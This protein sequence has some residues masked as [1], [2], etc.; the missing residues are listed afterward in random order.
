M[1]FDMERCLTAP[2]HP[3][4]VVLDTDAYNEVDD[5][6]AIAY[7][8]RSADRLH[9]KAIYAA[10]FFNVRAESAADG[11]EKSHAEILNVLQLMGENVPVYRGSER[12]LPDEKTPVSS[13]AA[14]D[15]AGLARAYTKEEPLYVLAIG[16]IT[17]V[18]SALLLAP[19][20]A[21]KLVVVWLG[22]HA[23]HYHDTLE[24]NLRQD[25]AAARVVM[26]SGVRFVQLPCRGVVDAFSVSRLELLHYL[27]EKSPICDYLLSHTVEQL[28]EE[29]GNTDWSKVLWDVVAIAWM[30]PLDERTIRT[31]AVPMRLP[32]YEGGY[33]PECPDRQIGYVYHLR[34]DEILADLVK[35]LC[36][37]QK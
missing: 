18:A 23:F 5:Q 28:D 29:C 24:F 31:R 4:D 33:E 22:G 37:V 2:K 9:T 20:I 14:S 8:L 21:E 7:L 35:K 1:S 27:S 25:V 36:I 30:L 16:A 6:F 12:F 11:M 19:D 32:D 15:L 17:N 3:V 10:P 13:A 26:Q 34:R